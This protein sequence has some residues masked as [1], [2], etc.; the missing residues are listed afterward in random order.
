[1]QNGQNCSNVDEVYNNKNFIETLLNEPS[2][3]LHKPSYSI[4]KDI[5]KNFLGFENS[6]NVKDLDFDQHNELDGFRDYY[7]VDQAI[8][9]MA[10]KDSIQNQ[11]DLISVIIEGMNL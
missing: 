10:N 7:T 11:S 5:F 3:V 1:M 6:R 4:H 9:L 2:I 8:E